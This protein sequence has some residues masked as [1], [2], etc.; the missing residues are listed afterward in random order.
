METQTKPC[1]HIRYAMQGLGDN[2]GNFCFPDLIGALVNLLMTSGCP[3]ASKG[4]CFVVDTTGSH[5]DDF[6]LTALSRTS[7][8]WMCE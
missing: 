8:S 5:M 2:A 3:A 7:W 1:R 4:F 6:L